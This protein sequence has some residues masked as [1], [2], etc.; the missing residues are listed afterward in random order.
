[1]YLNPAVA[2]VLGVLVL[3]ESFTPLLAAELLLILA[4]SWLATDGGLPPGT[5]RL[6]GAVLARLRA[7]RTDI[8]YA[9]RRT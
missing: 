9:T 5:A 3:G 1:T 6:A 7:R 8:R 4:G 2:V